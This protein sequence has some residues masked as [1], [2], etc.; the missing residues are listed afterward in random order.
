MKN[1]INRSF[2]KLLKSDIIRFAAV[3]TTNALVDFTILNILVVNG[4]TLAFF[5]F[6]Q[7]F[8]VANVVAF[9]VAMVNSFIWNRW[10]VFSGCSQSM[11]RQLILFSMITLTSVFIVNQL[12]FNFLYYSF[13]EMT[14]QPLVSL[15]AAKIL[16]SAVSMVINFFSYKYLVFSN[17]SD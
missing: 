2:S 4:Y 17:Q 8:L 1:F 5:L 9:S 14:N 13:I 15:N 6:N 3:G 7:K 12:L 11:N 10:W 16:A